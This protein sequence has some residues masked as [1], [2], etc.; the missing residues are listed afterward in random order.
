MNAPIAGQ[1]AIAFQ[2]DSQLGKD[3]T[4]LFSEIMVYK[5]SCINDPDLKLTHTA[6]D[7]DLI[8]DQVHNY[9]VRVGVEKFKKI[10]KKHTNLKLRGFRS[11]GGKGRDI[12]CFACI[13]M[14]LNNVIDGFK[15]VNRSAGTDYDSNSESIYNLRDDLI[16]IAEGFN[17][18]TGNVE[19][20]TIKSLNR[21][22]EIPYACIDTNGF[23]CLDLL[24][25]SSVVEPFTP[26]ELTGIY[27][28]EIGHI[29]SM[30]ERMAD[31]FFVR[32]RFE[33]LM[34]DVKKIPEDQV[35]QTLEVLNKEALPAFRDAMYHMSDDVN[36]PALE[37]QINLVSKAADAGIKAFKFSLLPPLKKITY[38]FICWIFSLIRL[39]IN[40]CQA[41][42][43]YNSFR[44]LQQIYSVVDNKGRKISDFGKSATNESMCERLADQFV[45]RQGYAVHLSTALTKLYK[46]SQLFTASGRISS[47]LIV[48]L[49]GS[50]EDIKMNAEIIKYLDY[51]N[52]VRSREYENNIDRLR[53]MVEDMY[54]IFK[55]A[56]NLPP[57]IINEWYGKVKELNKFIDS[58]S[59]YMDTNT[60]GTLVGTLKNLTS[61]INWLNMAIDGNLYDDLTKIFN[62]L[63]RMSSNSLYMQAARLRNMK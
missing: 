23:F 46:L 39:P 19:V 35:P 25:D 2:I 31:M 63:D 53:R 6:K 51:G 40:L 21:E 54:N 11:E 59:S 47:S 18:L 5:H 52:V 26:E 10:L 50:I 24:I 42:F 8:L 12:S 20:N 57:E 41:W 60:W 28:H 62:R 36:N 45:S 1:E 7:I 14:N 33:T 32:E 22:L 17:R 9:W 4:E 44:S 56:D 13:N 34:T 55:D 15:I 43:N 49:G 48:I 37:Q 61:P 58:Q 29:V 38:F 27:L 30:V 3:L 16:A